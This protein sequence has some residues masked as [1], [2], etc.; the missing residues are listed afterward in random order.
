[1]RFG[2]TLRTQIY[3]PWKGKYIDYGKLKTL[4]REDETTPEGEDGR[5]W[6]EQD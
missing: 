4:L 5:E 6:T 3:P 1:M 2:K